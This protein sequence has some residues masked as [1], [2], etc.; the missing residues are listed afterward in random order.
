MRK[1]KESFNRHQTSKS[2]LYFFKPFIT[3]VTYLKINFLQ[4]LG[5]IY[6]EMY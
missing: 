6:T 2:A 1:D 4:T 3:N 5:E